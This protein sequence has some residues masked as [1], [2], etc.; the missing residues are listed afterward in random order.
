M[1]G[2]NDAPTADGFYLEV[3]GGSS[4]D[5]CISWSGNQYM[6][7]STSGPIYLSETVSVDYGS[8]TMRAGTS[9]ATTSYAYLYNTQDQHVG[10]FQDRKSV[11]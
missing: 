7:S 1:I 11:V 4:E 10:T 2:V 5:E 8:A 3:S 9:A 6:S